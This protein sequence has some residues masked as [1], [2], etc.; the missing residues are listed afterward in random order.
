MT[1]GRTLSCEC[2][3]NQPL[4]FDEVTKCDEKQLNTS[5]PT[6]AAGPAG[7]SPCPQELSQRF[8]LD[9]RSGLLLP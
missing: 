8:L 3:G 1:Q 6:E 4:D 5:A 2:S 9:Q 7:A